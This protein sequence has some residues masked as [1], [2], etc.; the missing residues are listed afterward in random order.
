MDEDM[1]YDSWCDIDEPAMDN[2][3]EKQFEDRMFQEA[4]NYRQ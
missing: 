2:F 1:E 4:E 3:I